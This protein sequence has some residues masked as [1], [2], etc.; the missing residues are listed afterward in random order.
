[1]TAS[2]PLALLV[3]YLDIYLRV[4]EIPDEANALNGLQVENRGTVQRI[5]AAVD[6]SQQTVQAAGPASLVLVHHG[7]FWDGSQPMTG[8]RYQRIRTLLHHDSALYA[9]HI[10]LDVHPE[11]GNN[12]LLASKLQLSNCIWFGQY[13]GIPIGVAGDMAATTREE[14]RARVEVVVGGRPGSA[15]LIPGG[16]ETIRRV[17]IVTGAGGSMI[18]AAR[19]A[20]CD[21]FVS[22][23]G[24]A[25]TYFDSL[26]WRINLIYA[27]HYATETFGVKALAAHLADRFGLPWEFNDHPTGM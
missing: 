7:L 25:H 20:G 4:R 23:E 6:A 9:A 27:G 24:A 8:R 3:S 1:V 16:P 18:D 5:V 19:E 26:E 2:V 12:A 11:V 21:T 10:P 14:L 13:R 15:R 22:G 17:G